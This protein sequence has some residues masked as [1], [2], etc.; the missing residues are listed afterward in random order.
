MLVKANKEK[1][2]DM[3]KELGER[4]SNLMRLHHIN[5][6]QLAAR[7]GTTQPNISK[8]IAG[9]REPSADILA[10]IATVLHTTSEHL[11][12]LPEK[13]TETPFGTIK[14][15]CA[16][17]GGNLSEDEVRELIMTLL[18]AREKEQ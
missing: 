14:A 11:L 4:I 3:S 9:Q 12:G 15:Y 6:S 2:Y 17:H 7:S 18:A 1:V 5:Q 13:E 8:Y 16:R 10:N